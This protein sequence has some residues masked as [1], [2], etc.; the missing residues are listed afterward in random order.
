MTIFREQEPTIAVAA[1]TNS[2]AIFSLLLPWDPMPAC[3]KC[4]PTAVIDVNES[5]HNALM[6][7]QRQEALKGSNEKNIFLANHPD[8]RYVLEQLSISSY[9][10]QIYWSQALFDHDR[11]DAVP[12]DNNRGFFTKL[13]LSVCSHSF[14]CCQSAKGGFCVWDDH[15]EIMGIFIPSFMNKLTLNT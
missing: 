9:P 15:L 13:S 6:L 14:S 1:A 8:L 10:I 3:I 5:L 11:Y 7:T 4:D 12:R 2:S